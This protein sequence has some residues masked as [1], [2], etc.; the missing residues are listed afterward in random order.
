MQD[1]PLEKKKKT[2]ARSTWAMGQ[3]ERV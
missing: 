2:N 3:L 1:D